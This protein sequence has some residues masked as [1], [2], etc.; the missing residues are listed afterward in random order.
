MENPIKMDDLGVPLFSE[1]PIYKWDKGPFAKHALPGPELFTKSLQRCK[2]CLQSNPSWWFQTI[3]KNMPV[4]LDRFPKV[5]GENF[6][7]IFELPPPRIQPLGFL[8]V[9]FNCWKKYIKATSGDTSCS[10]PVRNCSSLLMLATLQAQGW[11][12]KKGTLVGCFFFRGWNILPNLYKG[13]F[14]KPWHSDN[15]L[16]SQDSMGY[17]SLCYRV[18]YI[19]II[20]Q[21]RSP[22]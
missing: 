1:T 2:S 16:T 11:A 12:M 8:W 4:K 20:S 15:L 9:F 18:Y 3:S 17:T 14:Q 5:R 22:Y 13:L 6:K 21:Y 7:K 10:K 19:H